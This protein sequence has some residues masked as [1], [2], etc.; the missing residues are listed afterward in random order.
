MSDRETKRER[1]RDGKTHR[2]AR[3]IISMYNKYSSL[4]WC[5]SGKLAWFQCAFFCCCVRLYCP[6]PFLEFDF[7]CDFGFLSFSFH[8]INIENASRFCHANGTW[9]KANYDQCKDLVDKLT[10]G[11][12]IKPHVELA[13]NIYGAGYTLS[14]VALSL[15]LA[16][17]IH[18]KWVIFLLKVFNLFEIHILPSSSGHSR[19]CRFNCYCFCLAEIF[20]VCA[21]QSMQIY[22]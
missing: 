22:F 18:F 17:F 16:V 10:D 15:G 12:D 20:V 3:E 21:T 13:T 7:I 4:C 2:E 1:E 11:M 6:S 19:N 5:F 14:L 8:L 9:D